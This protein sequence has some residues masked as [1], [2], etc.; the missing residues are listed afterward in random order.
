MMAAQMPVL[1]VIIPL[2]GAVFTAF[3]NRGSWAWAIALGDEFGVAV[4]AGSLLIEVLS[5]GP[6]SYALGGWNPPWG[7]EY[8]VDALNGFV[9]VL[10]SLIGAVI[11]PYARV[12][13]EREIDADRQ[14]WFYTCICFACAACSAS[15]S[16]RTLS[17]HSCFSRFH[18][19][20]HMC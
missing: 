1:M 16:R 17:T 12:S 6:I 8:R 18:R 7:I 3:M 10:V 2:L 4:I 20:R 14:P 19:S 13:V 15:Q 5:T 11:M 9:L